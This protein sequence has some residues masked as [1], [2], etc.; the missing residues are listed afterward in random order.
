VSAPA[1]RPGHRHDLL[2]IGGG[3]AGSAAAY[4][5]AEHGLDVVFVERKRF[6]REKTCGDGLT[7]RAV[8]Q[9]H[10]M[11]L[12]ATLSGYH[13]IDGLRVI[14]HGRTLE[15]AWPQHPIYPD[16]GYACD[17]PDTF[18]AENSVRRAPCCSNTPRRRRSPQRH[19]RRSDVEGPRQRRSRIRPL[20]HR[21]GRLELR[22]AG[23]SARPA[24]RGMA[25]RGYYEARCD[26][27]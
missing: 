20:R 16:Y 12:A 22:S 17:A 5:A 8:K 26:D 11:G 27:P 23:R 7:P 9:L 3:P 10:D 2:V 18:V 25:I 13:R 6:P 24:S 21:G 1:P 15:L 19:A 14:A 4:W